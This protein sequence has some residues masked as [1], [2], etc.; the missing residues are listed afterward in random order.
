M[1]APPT[2]TLPHTEEGKVSAPP[3]T[4]SPGWA[5][6]ELM[7]SIPSPSMGEGWGGGEA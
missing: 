5:R 6:N 1:A 4:P 3:F 7:L 2:V